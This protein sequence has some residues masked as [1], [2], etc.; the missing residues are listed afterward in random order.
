MVSSL[1]IWRVPT[2]LTTDMPPVS[3]KLIA[4]LRDEIAAQSALV[5]EG[6]KLRQDLER[7][8]AHADNM[9]DKITDLNRSLVEARSEIKTLSTKLAAA[10]NAQAG[11][12]VPGSAVKAGS[13]NNR[14]TPSEVV[15]AAQAKEDLYGDLTGLIVRGL[16]RGDQEDVFDC[17]QTGRNGSESS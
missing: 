10:R 8:E 12:K 15:Q 6:D 13:G 4:Q 14:G 1:K 11:V 17:I 3:N 2:R 5:K 9:Q 16:K 7:N